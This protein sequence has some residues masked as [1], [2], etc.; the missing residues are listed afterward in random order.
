MEQRREPR[1]QPNKNQDVTV[2]TVGLRAGPAIQASIID[3]SRTGMRLRSNS[4]I[5]CGTLIQITLSDTVAFGSVSRCSPEKGAY[6]LGIEISKTA[7]V[8]KVSLARG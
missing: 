2:Q 6:V 8:K 5:N 1:F 7:P 3:V 4:P